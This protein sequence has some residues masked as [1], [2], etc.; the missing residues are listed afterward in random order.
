[1]LATEFIFV[2]RFFATQL[3]APEIAAEWFA[4]AGQLAEKDVELGPDDAARWANLG[5]LPGEAYREMLA[6]GEL[7]EIEHRKIPQRAGI[8]RHGQRI[9]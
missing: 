5:Y 1:M 2:F 6:S 7:A 9:A 3:A 8:W 4:L